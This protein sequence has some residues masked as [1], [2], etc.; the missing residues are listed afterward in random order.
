MTDQ[1]KLTALLTEFGVGFKVKACDNETVIKCRQGYDKVE[2][3]QWFSTEFVFN[4][5]GSF[6]HMGAWE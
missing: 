6:N 5:D 1:E 3:Y 4:L 2:G